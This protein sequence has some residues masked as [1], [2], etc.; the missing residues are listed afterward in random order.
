MI[1]QQRN[2]DRV[3]ARQER[4]MPPQ[5]ARRGDDEWLFVRYYDFE[6]AD[7]RFNLLRHH[8]HG[9]APGNGMPSRPACGPGSTP[10]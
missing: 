2:F 1:L 9:R 5:A 4:Y 6:G 3:L 8:R 10:S 7:L